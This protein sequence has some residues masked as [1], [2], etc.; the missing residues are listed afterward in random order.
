M[1]KTI[2]F[3]GL[4]MVSISLIGCQAQDA[5]SVFE[6]AAS[7]DVN[8]IDQYDAVQDTDLNEQTLNQLSYSNVQS[9]S[10]SL[11]TGDMTTTEKIEYIRSL[12]DE[13]QILHA[14]NILIR[15]DNRNAWVLL[16]DDVKLF[17][18]TELTISDLDKETLLS[19]K[20][21]LII[22]RLEVKDTIGD[23][24]DLLIELKGNYNLEHIDLVITNFETIKDILQLRNDHM[25]YLKQ[26][27]SDVN[28]MILGYLE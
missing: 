25:D 19:Y 3:I 12:Y 1:K 6:R 8:L 4:M 2:L 18:E 9:L 7:Y 22:R 10:L 28:T 24:K 27:L 5:L 20:D 14:H 21:E 26:V 11:S 17:R 16:K 15:V 13:I 23:I